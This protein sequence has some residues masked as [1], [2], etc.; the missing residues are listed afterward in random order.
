MTTFNKKKYFQTLETIK[1]NAPF[2]KEISKKCQF[3]AAG[4]VYKPLGPLASFPVQTILKYGYKSLTTYLSTYL[5]SFKNCALVS[6][7]CSNPKTDSAVKE[8][9]RKKNFKYC[10]AFSDG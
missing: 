5:P 10:T 3:F 2:L 9:K 8:K 7:P 4:N 6:S 1:N